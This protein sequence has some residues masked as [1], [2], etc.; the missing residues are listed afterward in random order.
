MIFIIITHSKSHRPD[1][2]AQKHPQNPVIGLLSAGGYMFF[3]L[4]TSNILTINIFHP[5]NQ[6]MTLL[7]EFTFYADVTTIWIDLKYSAFILRT[8]FDF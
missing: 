7:V 6:N 1:N 2:G 3:S 8:I 5:M 4:F